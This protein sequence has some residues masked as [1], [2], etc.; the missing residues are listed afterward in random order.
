MT[1]DFIMFSKLMFI[2]SLGICIGYNWREI[3]MRDK[4][5][6]GLQGNKYCCE[7]KIVESK[8][9][10]FKLDVSAFFNRPMTM[11]FFK[12]EFDEDG[13]ITQQGLNRLRKR[14]GITNEITR[15]T[16]H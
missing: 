13:I 11:W 16:E 15:S 2:M 8:E 12:N 5:E 10:A 6:I 1:I 14:M 3:T 4:Y 9:V 7:F